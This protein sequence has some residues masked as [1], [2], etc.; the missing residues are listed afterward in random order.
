MFC[1]RCRI[2]ILGR[3]RCKWNPNCIISVCR[4][5]SWPILTFC[6]ISVCN[7]KASPKCSLKD[8]TSSES[9]LLMM[10]ILPI[11]CQS[12]D[13]YLNS[14]ICIYLI[15]RALV[16]I[17]KKSSN[18][19]VFFSK[20]GL[21]KMMKSLSKFP[22]RRIVKEGK[23]RKGW[24]SKILSNILPP[25]FLLI[26]VEIDIG[27]RR[28][29]ETACLEDPSIYMSYQQIFTLFIQRNICHRFFSFLLKLRMEKEEYC[30]ETA[31]LEGPPLC[32]INWF[33]GNSF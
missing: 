31:R 26:S 33:V 27:K 19:K 4:V 14:T 22:K 8:L 5:K 18:K 25:R 7:K 20:N 16:I 1:W 12:C 17:L 21:C 2:A 11:S 24:T 3:W 10:M 30:L 29:L 13:E 9:E 15:L 28:I 6:V 32:C 23:L